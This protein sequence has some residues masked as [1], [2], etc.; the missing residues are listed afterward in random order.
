MTT[1]TPEQVSAIL[2]DDTS[3]LFPDPITVFCDDCGTEVKGQYIV[4][5]EQDKEERLEIARTHLRA[6]GWSCDEDGDFCPDCLARA[7]AA[8]TAP[9]GPRAARQLATQLAQAGAHSHLSAD[10]NTVCLSDLCPVDPII[11][12][13]HI[14]R[15]PAR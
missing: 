5:I 10:G 12:I 8:L 11:D 6:A 2:H 13:V 7:T 1:A 15:G 9:H 14:T 3:P 4:S